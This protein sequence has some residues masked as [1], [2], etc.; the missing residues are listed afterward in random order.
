MLAWVRVTTAGLLLLGAFHV[1]NGFVVLPEPLA[2][3]LPYNWAHDEREMVELSQ[4]S[5]LDRMTARSDV[6]LADAYTSLSV[7]T[8]SGRTVA[9]VRP[10]AFVDTQ[11]RGSD[12]GTFFDPQTPEATRRGILRKYGVDYLL[13]LRSRLVDDPAS[14]R[15]LERLGRTVHVNRRFVLVHVGGEQPATARP[16]GAVGGG[17][18]R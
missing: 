8:F 5:F 16:R 6:V 15:P 12:L 1:R 17:P 9:V 10:Q 2:S 11:Q 7:P 13:L 4:F 18:R 14:H 3:R